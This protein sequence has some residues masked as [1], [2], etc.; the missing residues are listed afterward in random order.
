MPQPTAFCYSPPNYNPHEQHAFPVLLLARRAVE[1]AWECATKRFIDGEPGEDAVD[2][3]QWLEAST[4]WTRLRRSDGSTPIPPRE[5]WDELI[6]TFDWCCRL[7]ELEPA[8]VREVGL[9]TSR[10]WR[11][12]CTVGGLAA[13]YENWAEQRAAWLRKQSEENLALEIALPVICTPEPLSASAF[14]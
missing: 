9:P 14:D 13:I 6:L 5:I 2:S 11:E 1:E 10:L 7:L 12:N 3:L 4:D 8:V